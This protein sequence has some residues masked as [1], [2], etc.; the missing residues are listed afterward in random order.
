MTGCRIKSGMTEGALRAMA[1]IETAVHVFLC[2]KIFF[3]WSVSKQRLSFHRIQFRF[4]P[5]YDS[6]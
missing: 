3:R 6:K 2:G 5:L 1:N 4:L